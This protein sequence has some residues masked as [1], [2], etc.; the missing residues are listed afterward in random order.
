MLKI[1]ITGGI[2]SGKS[3]VSRIFEVLG[4]PVYDADSRAK[5]LMETN[6]ELQTK[7]KEYFGEQ[8]YINGKLNRQYLAEKAFSHP[9]Q[10]KILNSFVHPITIADALRWMSEQQ[11]PYVVKEAA[12]IFESGSDNDLDGVIGVTAPETLRIKR[13]MKRDNLTEDEIRS[14]MNKQMDE[15]E[16]LQRCRWQIINDEQQPLLEQ[17][18]SLHHELLQLA[19]KN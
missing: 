8:S 6:A 10:L 13:V 5:K 12:L 17:I 7:I 18:F 1:G 15:R 9:E 11:T 4:V 2:G 14:R 3:T 19:Q 16:K